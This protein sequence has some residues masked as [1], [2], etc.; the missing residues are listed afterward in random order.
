MRETLAPG[1]KISAFYA[2]GNFEAE[3]LYQALVGAGVDADALM[4]EQ[5]RISV[6]PSVKADTENFINREFA[7]LIAPASSDEEA[8]RG[9]E[10]DAGHAPRFLSA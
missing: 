6:T 8:N 4:K 2:P 9:V 3:P 1:Q 7:E 10:G 5:I